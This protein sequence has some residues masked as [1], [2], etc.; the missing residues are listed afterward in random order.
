MSPDFSR[1]KLTR[2]KLSKKGEDLALPFFMPRFNAY[3][4]MTFLTEC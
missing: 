2:S 3:L 1:E 4:M